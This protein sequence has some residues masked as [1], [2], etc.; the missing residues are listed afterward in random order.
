MK[1]YYSKNNFEIKE[2]GDIKGGLKAITGKNSFI[3]FRASRTEGNVFRIIID[4]NDKKEA[5]KL[6]EE[7]VGVFKNANE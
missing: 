7:A 2:T 3:W 5:E 1:D 6:M 4:S